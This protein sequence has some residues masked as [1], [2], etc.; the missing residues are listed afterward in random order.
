MGQA[1]HYATLGLERD[2]T[3]ADI[4]AAYRY[5]ARQHHPDLHGGS[6][7]AVERTQAINAAHGVLGDPERR[8]AYDGEL[9][10]EEGVVTSGGGRREKDVVQDTM[11]RLQDFI[12]GVA[13]EVTVLDP[14]SGMGLERLKLMVPAGT[15]PGTRLRVARE[16]L[17]RGGQV[18]VRLKAAPDSRFKVRGSDVR[19]D[20]RIGLDRATRGGVE[21]VRGVEGGMVSVRIPARVPRGTVL[22]VV[23]EGLPKKGMGRGDLLVRIVYRPEVKV[24]RRGRG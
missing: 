12:R 3:A 22:R 5:L 14:G 19:C 9:E 8:L 1:D 6:A 16:G 2:C 23:G 17:M 15:V 10:R 7:E 11:L 20:L 18:T 13:L 21:M 24:V 4:R